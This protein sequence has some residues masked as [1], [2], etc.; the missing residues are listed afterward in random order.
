MTATRFIIAIVLAATLGGCAQQIDMAKIKQH[1]LEV[2]KMQTSVF[3]TNNK[4]A[5]I[6]GVIA[7]L[8]DLDFNISNAD[9]EQGLITAKKFG[10]YPIDMTVTIQTVS[11]TQ[12][13]V[14]AIAQNNL[15]TLEES[16]LYDRFFTTLKSY[17]PENFRATR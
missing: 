14:H 10:T 3:D 17:I 1:Q 6:R 5:I 8:Q 15:K 12:I 7:A 4:N 16:A 13:L 9:T 11:S 2:Q